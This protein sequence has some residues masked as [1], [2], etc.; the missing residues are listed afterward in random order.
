MTV[1]LTDGSPQRGN[2]PVVSGVR[3][4][5]QANTTDWGGTA[6]AAESILG[7]SR[8]ARIVRRVVRAAANI[9]RRTVAR[10]LELKKVAA[11][12]RAARGSAVRCPRWTEN[13][14]IGDAV[15]NA[16]HDPISDI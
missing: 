7:K 14:T 13:R 2:A 5:G 9:F 15:G 3:H 1:A 8:A 12:G 10:Q 16:A 4:G 11:M 6:D